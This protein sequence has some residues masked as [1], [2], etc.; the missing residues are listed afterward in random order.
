MHDDIGNRSIQKLLYRSFSLRLMFELSKLESLRDVSITRIGNTLSYG[1]YR[2]FTLP[3]VLY[4]YDLV[5]VK[6]YTIMTGNSC[7]R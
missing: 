1:F 6:S 5:T 7:R 3:V 4:D 2:L